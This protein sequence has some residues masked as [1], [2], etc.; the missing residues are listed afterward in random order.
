MVTLTDEAA[1]TSPIRKVLCQ[2]LSV[3]DRLDPPCS[4]L[5]VADFPT[6]PDIV[7]VLCLVESKVVP[8]I[9]ERSAVPQT[10]AAAQ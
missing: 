3:R 4:G 5:Q 8:T 6:S 2:D 1:Q 7:S 9:C 10:V